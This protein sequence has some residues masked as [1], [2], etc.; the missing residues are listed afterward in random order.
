MLLILPSGSMKPIDLNNSLAL[1]LFISVSI[2][3]TT[4]VLATLAVP[5][6]SS[7]SSIFPFAVNLVIST[8]SGSN[9]GI[10]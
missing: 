6:A 3:S 7:I 2:D 9:P 4:S 10:G 5:K 1:S 8:V